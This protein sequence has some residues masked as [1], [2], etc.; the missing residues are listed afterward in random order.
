MNALWWIKTLYPM[1]HDGY[2][3]ENLMGYPLNESRRDYIRF[4]IRMH[5]QSLI[6]TE[7]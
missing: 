7:L 6:K 2:V 3:I 4:C 1:R 5:R